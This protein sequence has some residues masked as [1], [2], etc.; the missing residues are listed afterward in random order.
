MIHFII[1]HGNPE[2]EDVAINYRYLVLSRKIRNYFY[3]PDESIC[4]FE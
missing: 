4:I 3:F 1:V 2:E